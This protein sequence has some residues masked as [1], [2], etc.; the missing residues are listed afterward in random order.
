[1]GNLL[2]LEYSLEFQIIKNKTQFSQILDTDNEQE[3]LKQLT[4]YLKIFNES[5][6]NPSIACY[7]S[8]KLGYSSL[9]EMGILDREYT[10]LFAPTKFGITIIN[11][12][13]RHIGEPT[14]DEQRAE[15]H[16]RI[17]NNASHL[18]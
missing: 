16:S 2:N 11:A 13:R 9:E 7:T 8:E 5:V 4:K 18:S 1:M 12:Y 10:D 3:I 6:P 15:L 14:I 17:A